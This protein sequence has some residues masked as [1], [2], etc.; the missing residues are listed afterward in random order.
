VAATGSVLSH[1]LVSAREY[2]IPAIIELPGI[3]KLLKD[4]QQIT[5]DGITGEVFY[6]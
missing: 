2:N 3:D 4:G 1:G 6:K 5:I